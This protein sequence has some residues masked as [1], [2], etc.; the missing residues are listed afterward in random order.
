MSRRLPRLEHPAGHCPSARQGPTRANAAV[1]AAPCVWAR[2]RGMA[3]VTSADRGRARGCA[4][5]KGACRKSDLPRRAQ[6]VVL[7]AEGCRLPTANAWRAEDPWRGNVALRRNRDRP[8]RMPPAADAGGQP[9]ET[10]SST[11]YAYSGSANAG[12]RGGW[13]RAINSSLRR[14]RPVASPRPSTSITHRGG[15]AITA[16]S[17]CSR[18]FAPTV[19]SGGGSSRKRRRHRGSYR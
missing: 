9:A 4:D 10:I 17:R 8:T 3:S 1:T 15:T 7:D 13:V 5:R 19:R 11:S 16:M 14:A 6:A 18:C 2:R 12:T